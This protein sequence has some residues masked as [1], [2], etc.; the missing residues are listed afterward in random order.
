M[1]F[2]GARVPS[3][4]FTAGKRHCFAGNGYCLTSLALRY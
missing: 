1:F 3:D 2:A 4:L